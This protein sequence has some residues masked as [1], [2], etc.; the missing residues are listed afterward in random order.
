MGSPSTAY[1][2]PPFRT[3]IGIEPAGDGRYRADLGTRWTVGPKVHG[4]LLLVLM[5]KAALTRLDA[6]APDAAPD[7]LAVAADFLRAPEPGPVELATDVV[8]LGRTASVVSV[9]M[10]QGGKAMLTA[11]VT[12]G[13]LPDAEPLWAELPDLPATPPADAV[14]PKADRATPGIAGAC[15]MRYV[16]STIP[17]IRGETGPPVIQGWVRPLGEEPDVLFALLAGDLLPPTLFNV[18][19]RF[20]WA[21]TVQ[22]TALLRARPAPGWLRLD[23]RAATIG[24]ERFDEDVT[25][26]DSAGNLVCQARQLALAPR[27]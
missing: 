26:V 5:A 4:G 10:T 11:S 14:A 3:A 25:V 1:D 13:R 12:A 17:F 15:E 6:A 8:K 16:G 24:G 20:G 23:S 18:L 2:A 9:R 22:L 21:P 7:P 27:G 19:G